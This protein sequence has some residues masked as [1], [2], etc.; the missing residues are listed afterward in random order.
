[1]AINVYDMQHKGHEGQLIFLQCL[2]KIMGQNGMYD[3][4]FKEFICDSAQ[5][6]VNAVGIVFGTRDPS[7]PTVNGERTCLCYWATNMDKHTKKFIAKKFQNQ[8][9]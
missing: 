2:Y 6:N 5:N 9:I 8:H 1:M 7:I 3:P 4:T